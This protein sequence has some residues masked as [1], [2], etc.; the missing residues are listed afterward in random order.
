MIKKPL[1]RGFDL[2]FVHKQRNDF[3]SAPIALLN[4]LKFYDH[5]ISFSSH[6][7]T[8]SDQCIVEDKTTTLLHF[9]P[10]I[11]IYFECEETSLFTKFQE[12][13]KQGPAILYHF[14]T[15]G[16][17]HYSFWYKFSFDKF[18]GVNVDRHEDLFLFDEKQIRRLLL[19][20]INKRDVTPKAFLILR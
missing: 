2:I 3:S 19:V 8:L 5:T 1:F 14:D 7:K 9:T 4:A 12:H 11:N 15:R 20:D 13:L 17:P 16:E 10:I 6:F 18:Y